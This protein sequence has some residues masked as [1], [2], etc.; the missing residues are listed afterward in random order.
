[1][2]LLEAF[3]DNL[4]KTCGPCVSGSG[5]PEHLDDEEGWWERDQIGDDTDE[6]LLE[7]DFDRSDLEAL[8]FDLG[9][10]AVVQNI[11]EHADVHED[12]A[13]GG[14]LEACEGTV[15]WLG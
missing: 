4:A 3:F 12:K 13:G 1:M 15:G 9:C 10:G 2:A 7:G 5:S 14:T 11:G 8:W 6:D